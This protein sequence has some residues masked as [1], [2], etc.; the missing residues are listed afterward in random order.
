MMH[1][2]WC[3][4]EALGC[5]VQVQW[6][7]M[8]VASSR[9]CP[10]SQSLRHP[11]SRVDGAWSWVHGA[12]YILYSLGYTVQDSW[13]MIQNGPCIEDPWVLDPSGSRMGRSVF[14]VRVL[15]GV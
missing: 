1:G 11:G 9:I 3:I 4:P 8:Y 6:C 7:R 14:L 5:T 10:G 12:W 15:E 2:P 13:S